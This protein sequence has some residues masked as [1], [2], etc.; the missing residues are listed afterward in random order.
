MRH[1]ESHEQTVLMVQ[2]LSLL[3]TLESRCGFLITKN[4]NKKKN[5]PP[6]PRTSVAYHCLRIA[7][8]KL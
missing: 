8:P 2:V 3:V 5:R 7:A 1:E 4:N 6:F